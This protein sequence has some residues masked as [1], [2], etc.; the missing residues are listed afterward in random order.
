VDDFLLKNQVFSIK[1]VTSFLPT[2]FSVNNSAKHRVSRKPASITQT[3][4]KIE[5]NQRKILQKSTPHAAAVQRTTFGL[6]D[7]EIQHPSFRCVPWR[8]V[9]AKPPVCRRVTKLEKNEKTPPQKTP[10]TT[11]K[12]RRPAPAPRP[13]PPNQWQML[14]IIEID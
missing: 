2:V 5:K 9:T 4:L 1:S 8:A 6:P 3:R 7:T 12:H 11:T 13:A 10:K 14:E